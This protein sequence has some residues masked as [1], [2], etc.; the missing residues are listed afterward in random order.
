MCVGGGGG[1]AWG[2]SL[3]CLYVYIE[4]FKNVLIINQSTD[5][6]ITCQKT[7]SLGAKT[8]FP[9][10][11][12]IKL[13]KCSFINQWTDFTITWQECFFGDPLPRFFKSWF[14]QKTLLLGGRGGWL[15][16]PMYLYRKLKKYCCHKSL[17]QFQYNLAEMFLWWPSTKIVQAIMIHEKT[18]PSLF[19]LYI[20]IENFRNVLVINQWTDFNITW[21]E[22][23]FG[24]RLPR[25]F[26]PSLFVKSM[27]ARECVCVGGGG[28]GEELIFLI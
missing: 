28:G 2:Q 24:D 15:I 12:Y 9:L 18:W 23:F 8:Y 25:L 19:C 13:Y 17:Y 7:C 16:F 6:N 20:Y 4:N 22:C 27:A 3:F 21:Q 11:L 1:G 5:F 10:Y 26:K 14:V